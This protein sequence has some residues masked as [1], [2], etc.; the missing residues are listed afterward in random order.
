[1]IGMERWFFCFLLCM[2]RVS[3]YIQRFH[4][5][6]NTD[7]NLFFQASNTFLC[8]L[9]EGMIAQVIEAAF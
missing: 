8:N 1:M 6:L 4:V 7:E 9:K 2:N 5:K 3:T